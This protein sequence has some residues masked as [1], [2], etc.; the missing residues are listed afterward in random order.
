MT[1]LAAY[2]IVRFMKAHRN[3]ALLWS[4]WFSTIFVAI[5]QTRDHLANGRVYSEVLDFFWH[6]VGTILAIYIMY[7]IMKPTDKDDGS[8]PTKQENHPF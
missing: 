8:T 3:K 2:A 7:K 4:F 5:S 6:T 1:L